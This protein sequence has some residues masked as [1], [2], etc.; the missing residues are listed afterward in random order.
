V[1]SHSPHQSRT[2]RPDFLDVPLDT[3]T[4]PQ[5]RLNIDNK[6]RSNLFPWNGQFSPQLIEELLQAYA[7]PGSFMLDPFLGSGTV[8]YEAGR[9][10]FP[11]FGSEINPAAFKMADIYSLINV[12]PSKRRRILDSVAS[13]LEDVVPYD[14]PLFKASQTQDNRPLDE[15]LSVEAAACADPLAKKLLEAFVVLLNVGERTLDHRT[16]DTTWNKIREI[17]VA[18]PFSEA[19]INIVNCDARNLPLRSGQ[20]D[21]VLS[22]PPYINVFNYHQQYRKSVESMGWDLLEVAKSEI[23]SNRK[24]RGNRF[25]TVIQYCLDMLDVFI[26]MGRVCKAAARVIFVVGRESNVRKTVFYNG[27]IV[28]ALACRCAGFEL[29]ARQERVFQNRFGEMI[30]EDILHFTP[31]RMSNGCCRTSAADVAREVLVAALGRVPAESYSDLTS[32]IERLSD[33]APSPYYRPTM[34]QTA[35]PAH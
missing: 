16:V 30:F 19:P 3:A 12:V 2:A 5:D 17:V 22:S 32:A 1:A 23:G 20:V 35:D 14:T 15:V 13:L 4:I 8:V 31:R 7:K 11:A 29:C 27:E 28:A 6:E 26:E 21:L 34:T 10:G 25:L 33:V 9:F 24:N 18:L